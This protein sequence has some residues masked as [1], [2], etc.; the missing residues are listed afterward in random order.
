MGKRI[1]VRSAKNKGKNL[2]QSI[3][4][5]VAELFNIEFNN[6]DDSC[7]I[8]SRQMGGMGN[9]VY[10][11]DPKLKEQFNFSVECKSSESFSFKDTI[12]Q[13][14]NNSKKDE[15]WIIFHKR[16]CFKNSLVIMDSDVF[17]KIY[18]ELLDLKKRK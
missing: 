8:K 3:A 18:K 4:R 10:I 6:L 12:N 15:D 13:V 14:K 1:S 9:D 16:K 17:F 7:P 5:K 11:T 2:Q